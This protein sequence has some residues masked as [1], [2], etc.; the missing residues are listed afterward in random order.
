MKLNKKDLWDNFELYLGGV[1]IAITVITVIINVF[2]RYVLKFTFIWAEE[3]AVIGFVWTIFLGAAGA[4][5]H[6]MLM[7][8]DFLLQITKG[9][10]RALVELISNLFVFVV[11]IAMCSMSFIYVINS[12][13]ITA[14]LQISY[15]WLNVAIP[16]SFMMISLY[17]IINLVHN[18]LRLAGKSADKTVPQERD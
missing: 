14:A 8:V 3:I 2:T 17:A 13:K 15:K 16:L 4:F 12:K 18:I 9:K 1:F 7:G 6:K 10:M 5:K 11:A